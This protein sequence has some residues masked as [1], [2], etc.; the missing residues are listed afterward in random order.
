M[1]KEIPIIKIHKVD[2]GT[3]WCWCHRLVPAF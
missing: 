3:L 2:C 1:C